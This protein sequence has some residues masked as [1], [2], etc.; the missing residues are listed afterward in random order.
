MVLIEEISADIASLA[1]RVGEV[2]P[3]IIEVGPREGPADEVAGK[4]RCPYDRRRM[5]YERGGQSPHHHR[6]YVR[7]VRVQCLKLR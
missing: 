6:L 2:A 7:G 3:A 4:S 5:R 1:I